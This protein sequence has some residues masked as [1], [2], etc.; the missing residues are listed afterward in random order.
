M[1]ILNQTAGSGAFEQTPREREET[2]G[3]TSPFVP[4]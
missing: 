2:T 3:I 4:Q 1:L